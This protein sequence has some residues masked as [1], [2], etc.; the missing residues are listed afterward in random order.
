MVVSASSNSTKG[1]EFELVMI[2]LS[3]SLRLCPLVVDILFANLATVAGVF[4]FVL[5]VDN[6][7]V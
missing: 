2:D 3:A 1:L 4:C 5:E 7:V 6:L